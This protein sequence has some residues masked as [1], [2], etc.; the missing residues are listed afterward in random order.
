M[1]IRREKTH[2]NKTMKKLF[3]WVGFCCFLLLSAFFIVD[4]LL[5]PDLSRY[6]DRSTKV[7]SKDG[8]LL[9]AFLSEDD[10]WRFISNYEAMPADYWQM[11]INYEDKRYYRHIG[12]DVLA[13]SRAVTQNISRQ[14][15]VSGASTLTMQVAKLLEPRPRTFKSKL[16]EMFRALQLEYHFSKRQ[17]LDMYATLAPMG[18][19]KE[20]VEAAARFY[21]AKSSSALTIAEA[22]WLVALPK[23]PSR[24]SRNK[25]EAIAARNIVLEQA[26]ANGV[27]SL[28]DFTEAKEE[29]LI[30]KRFSMPF[31]APHY[32]EKLFKQSRQNQSTNDVIHTSIDFALQQQVEAILKSKVDKALP[33]T[34][35]AAL[36]I[37]NH[38][39][40][41]RAWV[42]S[43]D[44]FNEERL[45]QIDMLTAV[46]SPGSTL[47][48]FIYLYSF[49]WYNYQPTTLIADTP[50]QLGD[51]QVTNY[52]GSY[53]GNVTFEQSL[54]LSLNVAAVKLLNKMSA[55]AFAN[56]VESAG[57]QIYLPKGE[58][59]GLPIAL[60]GLG[61]RA[62]NLLMLYRQL[63][64]CSYGE[65]SQ[66]TGS[67]LTGSQAADFQA[68]WQV[69]RILQ[70]ATDNHG[71]ILF[72]QEPLA[73]KTGTSYGWR[74][75]WVIGFTKDYSLLV[76]SG[77][78]DGGYPDAQSGSEAVVPVLREIVNMLPNPPA[79]WQDVQPDY[80]LAMQDNQQLPLAIRQFDASEASSFTLLSPLSNS[81]IE[82]E[83]DYLG[84]QLPIKIKVQGGELP[85]TWLINDKEVKQTMRRYLQYQPTAGGR[86][87][88]TITDNS[89]QTLP[90]NLYIKEAQTS[91]YRKAKIRVNTDRNAL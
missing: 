33:A 40:E 62:D 90:L 4:L 3:K 2:L 68:C 50:M 85:I 13:L 49:A 24:Y 31:V 82:A 1:L 63:A 60:G 27:I 79:A 19:N 53:R 59:Y 30:I 72:G 86:L 69:R 25:E 91:H 52:D 5:P 6:H 11:L 55:A 10:K 61:V 23:N 39:G 83:Y 43:A 89:G 36:I 21:F 22:A 47:K 18:S 84:R 81:E 87:K 44:F 58:G 57:L 7:L 35:L 70:R 41:P 38:S 66:L 15:V 54:R 56:A 67:Q 28:K 71:R 73:F 32:A 16:I 78:P 48:P 37:D 45:G 34:N 20:G 12:I 75:R 14:Q 51:Y 65:N 88:M 74:D 8:K 29:P 76:W 9:R 26:L 77:R 46:R 17:I 80:L 64:L 42:G